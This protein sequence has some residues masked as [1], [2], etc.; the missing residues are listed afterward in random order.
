MKRSAPSCAVNF[1]MNRPVSQRRTW[2]RKGGG[3]RVAARLAT[4]TR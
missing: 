2:R 3:L 4:E 1:S